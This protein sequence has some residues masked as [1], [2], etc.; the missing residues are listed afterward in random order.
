[1]TITKMKKKKNKNLDFF[2]VFSIL[3][4]E[5][6]TFYIIVTRVYIKTPFIICIRF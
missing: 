1:M 3:F 6:A 4:T 2:F 5:T